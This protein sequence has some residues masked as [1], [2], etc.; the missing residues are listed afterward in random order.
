MAP[1]FLIV[2]LWGAP[3]MRVKTPDGMCETLREEIVGDINRSFADSA[4]FA[5]LLAEAAKLGHSHVS[6][7]DVRIWCTKT[8]PVI[9]HSFHLPPSLGGQQ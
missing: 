7:S 2:S 9:R 3:A 6:R 8:P 5:R 1:F 4:T